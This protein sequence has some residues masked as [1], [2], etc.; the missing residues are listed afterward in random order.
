MT[1]NTGAGEDEIGPP[2]H[3]RCTEEIQTGP[4]PSFLRYKH[5]TEADSIKF[6]QS[7]DL[8]GSSVLDIGA[9]RGIYCHFLSRSVGK[10]GSVTAFEPQPE[11]LDTI[12][13]VVRMFKL[14]NIDLRNCG[15]SDNAATSTLHRGKPEHGSASLNF[16]AKQHRI[17][18]EIETSVVTL[19][20][21][22]DTIPRPIRFIK[23]DIEGHEIPMLKGG[24]KTLTE[25]QPIILVEIYEK[26]VDE[27]SRVLAEY[28]HAGFFRIGTQ[29]Y[30]IDQHHKHVDARSRHR[31]YIFR[32]K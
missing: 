9:N 23:C 19:D 14:R 5:R 12:K 22:A 26:E 32:A 4:R 8:K 27:A 30:P 3:A 17:G 28:G 6:V 2:E 7:L 20:S 11:C 31:N 13:D 24:R 15:L 18:E 10:D 1:P 16:S 25:D 29:E 21:I